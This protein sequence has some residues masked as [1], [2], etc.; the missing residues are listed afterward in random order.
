LE[1]SKQSGDGNNSL[2]S[3]DCASLKL[4][5]NEIWSGLNPDGYVTAFKPASPRRCTHFGL[6]R[7]CDAGSW[8]AH[9]IENGLH[10]RT[11][12]HTSCMLEQ[13]CWVT[14]VCMLA[15]GTSCIKKSSAC[16][17]YCNSKD[18][19]P[20]QKRLCYKCSI[21]F[22]SLHKYPSM[23]KLIPSGTHV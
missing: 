2:P 4:I 5:L 1:L 18:R 22:A 16:C 12:I 21:I 20:T 15:K 14:L 6:H 11:R 17:K 13:E 7:S 10:P 8:M 23:R 9:S 3:Y 19:G